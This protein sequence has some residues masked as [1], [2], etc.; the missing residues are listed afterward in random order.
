[1]YIYF[2][3][4]NICTTITIELHNSFGEIAR[5]IVLKRKTMASTIDTPSADMEKIKKDLFNIAMKGEWKEV[6]RKYE[7]NN[8]AHDSKITRSGDTAL[9]IA[10]SDCQEDVVAAL[11]RLVVSKHPRPKAVLGIQNDRGNTPLHF[12]A[13]MGNVR[14]C[15]SMALVDPS[16]VGARNKDSETPLFMAALRGKK[17]AF[18]CMHYI[19]GASHGASY[20]RRH[21]GQTV[22]HCAIA[23]EYFGKEFGYEVIVFS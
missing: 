20:C 5:Q 21:D 7:Q 2:N 4:I 13:A 22:L 10:V 1:M 6:V 12:A 18:L 8:R 16:L 19:C 15:Q 14:M 3:A 23:G 17:E 9:H 11:V